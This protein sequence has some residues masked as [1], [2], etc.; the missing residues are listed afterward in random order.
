MKRFHMLLL[1]SAM[2]LPIGASVASAQMP[3]ISG[4][5]DFPG[6]KYSC[7][8]DENLNPEEQRQ[9]VDAIRAR[10]REVL[11]E[12]RIREIRLSADRREENKA[13]LKYA[14]WLKEKARFCPPKEGK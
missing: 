2:L 7:S 11:S 13:A 6:D 1:A 10:R 3:Y 9:A 4:V 14:E 5:P 12:S 8:D